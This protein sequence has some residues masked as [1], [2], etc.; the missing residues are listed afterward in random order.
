MDAQAAS[1][2]RPA[3]AL[4]GVSFGYQAATVL[5]DVTLQVREGEFVCLL[6]PSGFGKS[7]VLRLLAGL[8]SPQRGA[9]S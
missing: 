6:G 5:A 7:T 8:E 1:E 3:L 9:F 4:D 2:R